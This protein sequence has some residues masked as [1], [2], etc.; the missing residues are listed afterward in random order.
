MRRF[1]LIAAL[2]LV[3]PG[4]ASAVQIPVPGATDP[5]IRTVFYDP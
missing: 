4:A 2:V 3:V 5:R 1:V